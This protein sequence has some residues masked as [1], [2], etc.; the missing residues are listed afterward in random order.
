MTMVDI[1]EYRK[2]HMFKPVDERTQEHFSAWEDVKKNPALADEIQ[3]QPKED[4]ADFIRDNT[5][6]PWVEIK[7][8]VFFPAPSIKA[9]AQQ[10]LRTECFTSHRADNSGGWM[11][12]CVYGMSSVHTNSTHDY[13]LPEFAERDLSDWTDI[14]KFCPITKDWL[15]NNGLYDR[16]TRVR[17][18]VVLPGGWISPHADV[19]SKVG[20]GATN[21]SL[22]N[23]DGCGLVME[24]YGK[25]PFEDGNIFKINT[26]YE[27]AVYN[28][29]GMPRFHMIL[30]GDVSDYQRNEIDK[31]YAKMFDV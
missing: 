22:N 16:Y 13:Q 8:K 28:N 17:F 20:L 27:H 9:E 26:G 21:V 5:K 31:N 19:D 12:L 10:L 4:D 6:V 18:V 7:S 3:L 14:A 30:D 25:M 23:P 11:S 1:R 2:L 29:S 24:E 15:E